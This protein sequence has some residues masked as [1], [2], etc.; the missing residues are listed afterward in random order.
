MEQEDMDTSEVIKEAQE[1]FDVT[2]PVEIG[3]LSDVKEIRRIIPPAKGVKLIIKKAEPRINKEGTYRSINLTLGIVDGITY[4]EGE[5][6][7]YK[8]MTVFSR[9]CFYADPKT[10]DADY[11]TKRQHLVELKNLIGATQLSNP[12]TISDSTYEE[13]QGQ[14]LLGDIIQR[15]GRTYEDAEG[16]TQ[17]VDPSNEVVRFKKLPDEQLV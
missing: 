4:N 1:V 10:Y 15:K 6:P 9:V 17:T 2:E 12:N 5:E 11:F 7:K 8:N 14:V 3:D 16:N 13:L